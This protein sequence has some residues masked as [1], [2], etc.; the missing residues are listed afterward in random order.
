MSTPGDGSGDWVRLDT[1]EQFAGQVE[2]DKLAAMQAISAQALRIAIE[3]FPHDINGAV[4]AIVA[5]AWPL[6]EAQ[7]DAQ[8]PLIRQQIPPTL[9]SVPLETH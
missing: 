2:H 9:E 5:K 6:V 7:I 8:A 3:E 1:R 4:A